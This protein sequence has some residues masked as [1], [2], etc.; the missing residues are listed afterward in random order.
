MCIDYAWGQRCHVDYGSTLNIGVICRASVNP[1]GRTLYC[2][3]INFGVS[4]CLK[5]PC[6][7]ADVTSEF[8]GIQSI[9]LYDN[10]DSVKI[11]NDTDLIFTGKSGQP[12]ALHSILSTK[13]IIAPDYEDITQFEV[14]SGNPIITMYNLR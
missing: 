11:N 7:L 3:H 9:I 1:N 6:T 13:G 5:N 10:G 8:S 12:Y 4:K 2:N 14:V